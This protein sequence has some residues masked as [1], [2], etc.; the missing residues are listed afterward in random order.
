MSGGEDDPASGKGRR[1]DGSPYKEGNTAP[2]GSYRVGRNRAP[3][4]GKFR[5]NDGRPRGRRKQGV[6]NADTFFERELKR[7][8]TVREDGKERIVTK[9]QGVDLRLISLA[10]S[11]ETRAI[12]MVDRRRERIEG[13]K[14]EAA[15]QNHSLPDQEILDRY[16]AQRAAE[17]ALAPDEFGDPPSD[18]AAPDER[19]AVGDD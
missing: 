16:L 7:K 10:A 9:G 17:R 1:K 12:E 11:G 2:D 18:S 5:A 4:A 6:E 14:A 19:G 3:E 13:R 8:V 15:R